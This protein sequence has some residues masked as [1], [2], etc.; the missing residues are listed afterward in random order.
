MQALIEESIRNKMTF[1]IQ[2]ML[3][4]MNVPL[5][6][7]KTVKELITGFE[8]PLL[9]MGKYA[10]PNKVKSSKFSLLNDRNGTINNNVT[11]YLGSDDPA[12]IGRIH[13]FNGLTYNE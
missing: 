13:A 5:F 6:K 1:W 11:I 3:N 4:I 9:N 8:D 7:T 10:D 12:K 2:G